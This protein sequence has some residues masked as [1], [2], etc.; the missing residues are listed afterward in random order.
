M[1]NPGDLFHVLI[2]LHRPSDHDGRQIDTDHESAGLAQPAPEEDGALRQ[3]MLT[4]LSC[5]RA[6]VVRRVPICAGYQV[7]GGQGAGV[8]PACKKQPPPEH[9]TRSTLHLIW[10]VAMHL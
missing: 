3:G 6:W 5:G 1:W 4:T 9:I 2:Y 8:G 7:W 10:M